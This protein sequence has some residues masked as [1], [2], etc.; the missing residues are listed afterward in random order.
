MDERA[1]S[2]LREVMERSVFDGEALAGEERRCKTTVDVLELA[3]Q[4]EETMASASRLVEQAAV[5]LAAREAGE[6]D[7]DSDD[8]DERAVKQ[9][10]KVVVDLAESRK[11]LAGDAGDYCARSRAELAPYVASVAARLAE[12]E[13]RVNEVPGIDDGGD[14]SESDAAEET[15]DEPDDQEERDDG[16]PFVAPPKGG[17]YAAAPPEAAATRASAVVGAPPPKPPPPPAAWPDNLALLLGPV[18]KPRATVLKRKVLSFCLYGAKPIYCAGA[19][20]NARLAKALF[21]DWK[22]VVYCNPGDVP[23]E[24]CAALTAAG[25]ELR[26]VSSKCREAQL[27]LLRF[28]PCGE[29]GVEAVAVRDADSRLNPRDAAAVRAWLDSGRQFHVLH[30]KPHDATRML[31]GMW[32][33]RA[34]ARAPP[35]PRIYE[36]MVAFVNGLGRPFG[37]GDDMDFLERVVRPLCNAKN[38][39]HHSAAERG[40]FL[41]DAAPSPFPATGYAGFV[42]QPINCPLQ[43]DWTLFRDAGCAHVAANARVNPELAAKVRH[44]PDVLAGIG[45]FLGCPPAAP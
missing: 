7:S 45:A 6:L 43:C 12:A 18:V 21:P 17:I 31:G 20:Q 14:A 22:C 27:M 39:C 30:E 37:Y 25:A 32:G 26:L 41:A 2:E 42:G 5:E 28:L 15:D 38:V 33:A 24:T 40:A 44:Q 8:E 3:I 4:A 13:E 23:A 35:V 10:K 9:L 34:S 36:K 1:L 11:R 29:A 19:V 16:T